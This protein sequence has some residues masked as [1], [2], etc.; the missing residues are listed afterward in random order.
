MKIR[1]KSSFYLENNF[2]WY[3][4][5]C[6]SSKKKMMNFQ[7]LNFR[8]QIVDGRQF[9]IDDNHFA[10]AT[11]FDVYIAW[12]RDDLTDGIESSLLLCI[13]CV[14]WLDGHYKIKLA[15]FTVRMTPVLWM[16]TMRS[17]LTY[18]NM[19]CMVVRWERV[20]SLIMMMI[21]RSQASWN[22]QLTLSRNVCAHAH[23]VFCVCV[24]IWLKYFPLALSTF[25]VLIMVSRTHAHT[26]AHHS[27]RKAAREI[28]FA[29]SSVCALFMH[30]NTS[31]R[32][33]MTCG[34]N[35]W[36]QF[37]THNT[38]KSRVEREK[39]QI[40]FEILNWNIITRQ[41]GIHHVPC[42]R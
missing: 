12:H 2:H 37:P 32:R 14:I 4:I 33:W 19:C 16:N 34:C 3:P 42:T 41:C 10:E 25:I 13:L 21:G 15:V 18:I 23:D 24:W 5:L 39:K 28:N 35:N 27:H 9:W 7:S 8:V 40:E 11:L 6:L 38:W 31:M 22:Q 36:K 30:A 26:L 1:K 29:K 17:T 20:S